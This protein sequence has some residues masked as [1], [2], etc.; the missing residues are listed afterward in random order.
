MTKG[1]VA[2]CRGYRISEVEE[3]NSARVAY[4]MEKRKKMEKDKTEDETTKEEGRGER[5]K[6]WLPGWL[7]V[8][9]SAIIAAV[10]GQCKLNESFSLRRPHP[11]VFLGPFTLPGPSSSPTSPTPPGT[12]HC[13]PGAT[14]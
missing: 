11:L 2:A 5:N 14:A 13:S 1:G 4:E 6:A 7:E 12:P 3:G 8:I 10:L 9:H